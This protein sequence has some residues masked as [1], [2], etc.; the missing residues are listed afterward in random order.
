MGCA[1]LGSLSI[2]QLLQQA[3]QKFHTIPAT[4]VTHRHCLY[5]VSIFIF[6]F[7]SSSSLFCCCFFIFREVSHYL[8]QRSITRALH[9]SSTT[10]FWSLVCVVLCLF[11]LSLFCDTGLIH[12]SLFSLFIM[13]IYRFRATLSQ[14]P[15]TWKFL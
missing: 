14:F 9:V 11:F 10:I 5:T 2:A 13:T 7:F 6:V 15:F 3:T 4:N 12:Q 1:C 8:I